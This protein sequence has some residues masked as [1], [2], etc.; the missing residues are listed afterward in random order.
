MDKLEKTQGLIEIPVKC[1]H[2]TQIQI[3]GLQGSIALVCLIKNIYG[4]GIANQVKATK[5]LFQEYPQHLQDLSKFRR[6][7]LAELT[8]HENLWRYCSK[9]SDMKVDDDETYR[10]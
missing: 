4:Q 5:A 8:T 1:D 10:S 3:T 2:E 9:L 6:T 7:V